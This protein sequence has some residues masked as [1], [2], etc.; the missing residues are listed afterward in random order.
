NIYRVHDHHVV[1]HRPTRTDVITQPITTN[2][3]LVDDNP[4]SLM[5]M[6]T[7]LA[8]PGRTIVTAESGQD[9]LRHLLQQDFA[10]ILLDVRMPRLDGFE[11]AA[12]IRQRAQSRYT[13]SIFM[14]AADAMDADV[15]RGDC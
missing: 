13:P 10:V 14:S 11:T 6:E 15:D 9:A 7:L 8:G 1:P 4:G 12:L 2:I 5:A 3:M